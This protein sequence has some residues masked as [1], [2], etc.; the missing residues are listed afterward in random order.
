MPLSVDAVDAHA[1]GQPGRVVLG[2]L[3][4]LEVRGA[5]MLDRMRYFQEHHDRFR[6]LMLHEPRGYPQSCLNVVVP[7]ADPAADVGVIVMLPRTDYPLMSG[8][9]TM[10]VTTVLLETGVLPMTEP[11]TEVVLDLPGGTV[12]VHA[13]CEAGRVTEVRFANLPSFAVALGVPLEVEGVGRVEVDVAFG[14]MCYALADAEKLGLELRPEGS[15]P[16]REVGMAIGRAA[17]EQLDLEHPG[18]DGSAGIDGAV[19][20]APARRTE[21]DVSM[22]AVLIGGMLD[23]TPSGT[24]LSAYLAA[25]VAHG[26]LEVGRPLRAE[27]IVGAVW[28]GRARELTT[29]AGSAAIVPEVAGRAWISAHARYVL[30]DDD[31]F[32]TGFRVADLWRLD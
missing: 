20:H 2:G 17:N 29:V 3:G 7:P 32:P 12:R 4:G 15:A 28:Q 14:G 1:G 22:T 6:Q 9:N 18:L 5:T 23:R 19:L 10:C 26:T 27:G 8:T 31:P 25:R 13:A 11:V 24:G 16:V 30:Q 21:A